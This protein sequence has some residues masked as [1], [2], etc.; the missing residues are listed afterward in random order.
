MTNI[1]ITY[2]PSHTKAEFVNHYYG[3]RLWLYD[4]TKWFKSIN[5]CPHFRVGAGECWDCSMVVE[6]AEE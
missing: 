6:G 4:D 5:W 3:L 1:N 2:I